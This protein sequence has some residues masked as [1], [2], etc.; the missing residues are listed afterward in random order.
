MPRKRSLIL[1]SRLVLGAAIS[2]D[3]KFQRRLLLEPPEI[4]YYY[5]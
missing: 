3:I 5:A 2:R 4:T 1:S